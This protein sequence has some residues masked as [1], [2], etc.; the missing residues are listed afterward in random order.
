MYH[1]SENIKPDLR[2]FPYWQA[3]KLHKKKVKSLE[4]LIE[5]INIKSTTCFIVCEFPLKCYDIIDG[6]F[7]YK[8]HINV[9]SKNNIV[10]DIVYWGCIHNKHTVPE[11]LKPLLKIEIYYYKQ[12]GLSRLL[13]LKHFKGG[14]LWK[15]DGREFYNVSIDIPDPFEGIQYAYSDGTWTTFDEVKKEIKKTLDF[16]ISKILINED[17]VTDKL[18]KE[19]KKADLKKVSKLLRYI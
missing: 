6:A 3:I 7:Y 10:N 11:R 1:L 4:K 8:Y 5:A 15:L 17:K 2:P 19:L 14:L 9:F 18:I 12:R 13:H 16:I